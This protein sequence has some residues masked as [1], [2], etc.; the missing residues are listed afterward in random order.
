NPAQ[1]ISTPNTVAAKDGNDAAIRVIVDGSQTGGGTGFVLGASHSMVRGLAIDGFG[2]GVSVPDPGVVGT[3]IQG[4]F[5]GKYILFLVDPATG[6][7]LPDASRAILG[8]RGNSAQGVLLGSTNATVGG[9][10]PQ[11]N[12]VIVGNGL[13]GVSIL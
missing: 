12:N 8:G 3:L 9:T 7:S 5:I 13:Q 1:I 2:V 10:S 4:N 11:E 6:E